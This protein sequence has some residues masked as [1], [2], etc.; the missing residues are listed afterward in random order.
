[1]KG[2]ILEIKVFHTKPRVLDLDFA[3]MPG[4]RGLAIDRELMRRRKTLL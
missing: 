3:V 4:H 1:M 2:D